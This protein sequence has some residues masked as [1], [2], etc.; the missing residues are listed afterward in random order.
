MKKCS[1]KRVV[2]LLLT[3]AFGLCFSLSVPVQ[4]AERCAL[5]TITQSSGSKTSHVSIEAGNHDPIVLVHGLF[6]WG[7]T[8]IAHS[9]YWG[10]TDSLRDLLK[11][12]GYTVYTPTIGPV[13]SNWDRACE[14]YAY[15]VGGTVDYGLAHSRK[16]GHARYG[17]TFAGVLPQLNDT[18]SHL[19][20]H[21]VGHSMGGE[22]IRMLAQLLENGDAVERAAG[23]ANT[24]SPLFS[25]KCRHWIDSV[26]TIATPHDGSQFDNKKYKIEPLTHQFIAALAAVQGANIDDTNL[27]LDFKLGQWGIEREPGESY[28][29]YFEKVMKSKLWAKTKDLSVYDLDTDGA[30]VLNAYAKAQK[31]IYYFSIACTDTYRSLTFPHYQVPYANMN[32]IL[33]HSS[34]YM[35]R[36]VNYA[37]GHVTIDHTW[38]ENDGIVSVRSAI[39]PHSGSS[40]SFNENYG[41]A[42]DGSY[43]F[44]PN[45][46]KGTWNYIEK[47]QKTDHINVVG[48]QKNKQFLQTKFYQLAGMLKSIPE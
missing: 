22:T 24:I 29:S 42:L 27:G 30:A 31:D 47:I 41:T 23:E 48:Q 25:G 8:E 13:S 15:L 3:F 9:N 28:H 7:N 39:H 34:L 36:Y 10:G 17:S 5:S 16:Y 46:Q 2:S 1:L 32:P 4:A 38:W 45:T 12:K 26:T 37:Y 19:K 11:E 21:L 44:K 18:N 14:L 33:L 40:D 6:G 35:G 43:Q 20:I